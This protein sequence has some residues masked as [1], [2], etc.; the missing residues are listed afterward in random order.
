MY[1]YIDWLIY[2]CSG[3]KSEQNG[4]QDLDQEMLGDFYRPILRVDEF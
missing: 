1:I 2:I 3:L 4:L